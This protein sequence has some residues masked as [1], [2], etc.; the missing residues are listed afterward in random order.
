MFSLFSP[1]GSLRAGKTLRC[2][3]EISGLNKLSM[4]WYAKSFKRSGNYGPYRALQL[5]LFLLVMVGRQQVSGPAP[6]GGIAGYCGAVP[7][8][9]T[10]F[11]PPNENCAPQ[12]KIVPRRNSQNRAIGVQ[13]EA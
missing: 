13:I 5:L 6:Q 12:A 4:S 9:M 2:S 8:Q 10:A 7:P 1:A 11:S 3:Y